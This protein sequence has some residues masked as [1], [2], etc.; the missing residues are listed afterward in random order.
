MTRR[1]RHRRRRIASWAD[2]LPLAALLAPAVAIFARSLPVGPACAALQGPL[3]ARFV[4]YILEWGYLHL[5][6]ATAPDAALW[7]PPFFYPVRHVLAYSE[8]FFAA[9]PFYFPLRW[10][11]L[12][13]SSALFAFHLLQRAL[14]PVVAYLC[15]RMLRLGRWPSLV[16]AAVFSWGW[17]RYFHFGHIQF[18]AGY[19]IPLF[20]TA[21][22]FAFYRRR[23][24][25]LVLAAWTFLFAWYLS[26]YTAVFLCL[27]TLA[28]AGVQ[29]LLPGGARELATVLR[30]YGHFAR[31]RP[32]QALACF[33]LSVAALSLLVPS[34]AIYTEVHRGFGPARKPRSGRI[35]V[36]SSRGYAPRG[37]TRCWAASTTNSRRN[38][39]G[40]GRRRP[41]SDGS[42]SRAWC[43]PPPGS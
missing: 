24:W 1:A 36:T 10:L 13:P 8:N 38:G 25:A 12:E 9:Y 21:L 41:F 15:L 4:G 40:S 3:D 11:G 29:L 37:S 43:C 7:S 42:A 39:A 32:R 27:A 28:L 20:F 16:G 34:A 19:P 14:T 30:A 31:S 33:V 6:G 18:A 5:H 23:P 22:Y 35:G 17:I 26:L 2:L